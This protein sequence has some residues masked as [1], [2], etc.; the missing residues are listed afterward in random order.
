MSDLVDP[1]LQ[2]QQSLLAKVMQDTFREQRGA[3]STGAQSVGMRRST[4]YT[5]ELGKQFGREQS[6]MS[7][8]IA[9]TLG[10]QIGL[11]EA[12]RGRDFTAEQNDL[13]RAL[14]REMFNRQMEMEQEKINASNEQAKWGLVKDAVSIAAAPFTG[15]ASLYGLKD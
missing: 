6:V 5:N 4:S 1:K 10:K 12:Q 15:G 13:N 2:Q 3:S 14:E 8:M 11:D 9:D 7:Q